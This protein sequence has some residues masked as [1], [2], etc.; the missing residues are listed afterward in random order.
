MAVFSV[1]LMTLWHFW[2]DPGSALVFWKKTQKTG[3]ETTPPGVATRPYGSSGSVKDLPPSMMGEDG[4]HMLLI[5]GGDFQVSPG[6]WD[7]S[8]QEGPSQSL[9]YG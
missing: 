2:G 5:P 1:I 8:R 3:Q 6:K 4:S 9:L 7:P